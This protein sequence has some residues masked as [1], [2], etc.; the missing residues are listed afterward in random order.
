MLSHLPLGLL[1]V[2]E[3]S[4]CFGEEQQRENEVFEVAC[5]QETHYTS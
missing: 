1:F 2:S 3:S 5:L 4:M